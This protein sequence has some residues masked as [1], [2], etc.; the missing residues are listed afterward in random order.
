MKRPV[1][2]VY[3]SQTGFT[4]RYAGM[5]ARAAMIPA[6]DLD[7]R[8]ERPAPGSPVIYLGWLRAEH[9]KGLAQARRHYDI[10]A[11]CAVGLSRGDQQRTEKLAA[12]SRLGDVPLFYLRGGYAPEKV[13]G[14]DALMMKSFTK[15]LSKSPEGGGQPEML[16]LVRN[17]ADFVSEDRLTPVLSWLEFHS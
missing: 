1:A 5:L 17:G 8:K 10:Q 12:A 15:L 11:V 14:L 3:T 13:K 2:I 6:Y 7:D 9:I 4:A 16:E